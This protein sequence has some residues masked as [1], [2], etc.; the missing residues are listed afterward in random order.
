MNRNSGRSYWNAR[1]GGGRSWNGRSTNTSTSNR[2]NNNRHG[3]QR[4]NYYNSNGRNNNRSYGPPM[5]DF[6]R[7]EEIGTRTS[8][9][10]S[11][12]IEGCCH[13]QLTAIYDRL[14]K[15]EEDETDS[16]EDLPVTA[17]GPEKNLESTEMN[18]QKHKLKK[19]KIDLLICC[20][21]FQSLRTPADFHSLAVPAKYREMGSFYKYYNKEW[22]APVLTIFCG[23][24]HEASQPLSELYYGG[25]V[26][27]K[28]YYLGAAGVIRYKGIRI[29]GLSGI[30]KSHDYYQSRN[31]IPPYDAKQLRSVYHYRNVDVYRLSCLKSCHSESQQINTDQTQTIPLASQQQGQRMQPSRRLDIVVSHDWPQGIEQYGDVHDLIRRKP[32][33]RQEINDN[34]LGSPPAAL[35]L[36]KLQPSYWFAAHLHVKFH[37]RIVHETHF[38][39]PNG[40]GKPRAV[41]EQKHLI[42]SQVMQAKMT[43]FT[44]AQNSVNQ[45]TDDS[46]RANIDGN[47]D[48]DTK[49]NDN[50]EDSEVPISKSTL[51]LVPASSSNQL[52]CANSEPDLTQLMTQFLSL[53]KCLPRRQYLS[54]LH[55]PVDPTYNDTRPE[56]NEAISDS[57]LEYDLEWLAII[58]KTH[59][60]SASAYPH[61]INVP[62]IRN[63]DRTNRPSHEVSDADMAWIWETFGHDLTI[64]ENFYPT[65]AQKYDGHNSHALPTPLPRMGNPQTDQLLELLQLDHLSNLTIPYCKDQEEL[66]ANP[67]G[68]AQN[69]NPE[70]YVDKDENEIELDD[71]FDTNVDA[72]V[73]EI[74]VGHQ[75]TKSITDEGNTIEQNADNAVNTH[76]DV[77]RPRLD[78]EQ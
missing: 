28:M 18:P 8:T 25:W 16:I 39:V 76:N 23:G 60:L 29:G 49:L 36:H 15:F 1:G 12:A 6:D 74:A 26:A 2:N 44:S 59:H 7:I 67:F 71:D 5:E 48:T 10:I 57:N 11:I 64:P 51:F 75:L 63:N 3:T 50:T 17:V 19:R 78:G 9:S 54:I 72:A 40:N 21:D 47:N 62:E 70:V 43:N 53:D 38:P 65:L 27:P 22:E 73:G 56:D 61:R 20:G 32:F 45:R 55:L 13:G 77:K 33:F 42:P 4:R 31:E 66:Q 68:I 14:R 58:R 37:A 41:V 46:A 69:R 24:N 35:L 34:A 52:S 30:Y